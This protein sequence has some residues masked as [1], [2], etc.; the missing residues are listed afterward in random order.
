MGNSGLII[1]GL[2]VVGVFLLSRKNNQSIIPNLINQTPIIQT[3]RQQARQMSIN[4]SSGFLGPKS[5]EVI[6]QEQF[7]RMN[8]AF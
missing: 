7:S 4:G 5:I 8:S 2:I 6:R 3:P 1:I